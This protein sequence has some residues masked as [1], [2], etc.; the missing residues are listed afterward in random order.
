MPDL[1]GKIAI[2]TG[3]NTGIG[4]ETAKVLLQH[5]AKVYVAARSKERAEQAIDEIKEQ[6]GHQAQFLYLDLGSLKS[7]KA[8]AEEFLSQESQLHMLFNNAGVMHPPMTALTTEGYDLQFGTNV[9]GHFYFTKLLLPVLVSTAQSSPEKNVRVVNTSSWSHHVAYLDFDTF[10]DTPARKRKSSDW[11]YGQSKFGNI[12]FS[13]ELARRYGDQGIVSTSLHPGAI[14][15]DLQ[16]NE[17]L[18][19]GLMKKSLYT[20]E[21]GALSQLRAGTAPE[22]A[23]WN[24]KYLVPWAKLGKPVAGTNDPEVG[25]R[26]WDWLEEQVKDV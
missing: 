14:Y 13:N 5:N 15:T 18:P 9:L 2:V 24:G 8:A 17:S 10:K 22:A 3:A 12:V 26:L 21:K 7:V 20:V 19:K 23:A 25:K 16:R 6:T 4:K 11:L 1:T